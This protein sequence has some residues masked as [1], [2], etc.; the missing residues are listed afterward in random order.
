MAF[1]F[2]YTLKGEDANS[3]VPLDSYTV[4]GHTVLGANEYFGGHPKKAIWDKLTELQKQQLL[5]RA[6]VRLDLEQW[7][8]RR[9]SFEQ[10]LQFPRTWLVSRDF[11]PSDDMV[12]F[13][14]GNYYQSAD[15]NPLELEEATCEL[16]LYYAE[17]W[18]NESPIVSRQ[19]QERMESFE[20]GP[21]KATMR[22]AKEDQLPDTVKRLL[23]AI[24]PGVWMGQG[25]IK[26]LR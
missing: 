8:G 10:R 12:D 15:Y 21:L 1:T 16:A 7:S 24:G 26:V 23:R 20:I 2:D 4:D 3:Y 11:I 17:E 14:N 9:S 19:N 25:P 22:K 18:I 5:V 13:V 6:T